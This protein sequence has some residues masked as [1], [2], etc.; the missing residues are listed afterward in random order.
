MGVSM[1]SSRRL[2]DSQV[3]FGL[4]SD[5]MGP[6][7]RLM[8]RMGEKSDRFGREHELVRGGGSERQRQ[9]VWLL[10]LLLLLGS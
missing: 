2:I 4:W 5:G 6:G 7:L 8:L 3:E 9:F 10:C 1:A